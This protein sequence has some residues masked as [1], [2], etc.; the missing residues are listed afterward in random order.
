MSAWDSFGVAHGDSYESKRLVRLRSVDEL[1]PDV[2][3]MLDD[4]ARP[5]CESKKDAYAQTRYIVDHSSCGR[6]STD[7]MSHD[8]YDS[9]NRSQLAQR[10]YS[11]EVSAHFELL[12]WTTVLEALVLEAEQCARA[13]RVAEAIA[14][15]EESHEDDALVE[16]VPSD[17]AGIGYDELA[18]VWGTSM[19]S[20]RR[21][22]TRLVDEGKLRTDRVATSRRGAKRR[23]FW[24]VE[25]EA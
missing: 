5:K 24:R 1:P 21:A 23:V 12:V 13:A 20:A 25:D 11:T 10:G 15:V 3:A 17:G 14:R 9:Y 7:S 6:K 4:P 19:T 22:A 18:E 16:D 2:R 8:E